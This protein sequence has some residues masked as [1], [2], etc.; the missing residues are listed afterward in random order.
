MKKIMTKKRFIE[1]L[2]ISW[3]VIVLD[4]AFYFFLNPKNLVFG[5]MMGV[6]T[7]LEPIL[8]KVAN[9]FTASI[10]L[11]IANGI[12]LILGA[13]LLG[14]DFFIKTIYATLLSPAFL[15]LLEQTCNKEFFT[16]RITTAGEY[17]IP[18]LVGGL[19]SGYGIG[20]AVKNN[21]STGG[22]DVIQKC[23]SKYL[24]IPYS[25]TMYLTDWVIVI[26]SGIV[27]KGGFYY[28]IEMV[29]YGSLGI[30]LTSILV[31]KIVLNARSRRTAYIIT[32]KPIEMRDMLYEKISRGVTFS[33]VEGGYTGEEKMMVICTMEKSEAYRLTEF[34]KEVDPDSFSFITSCKEVVGEYADNRRH[35]W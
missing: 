10:F 18:V 5:G 4:I 2:W 13:I 30:L 12:C 20:V 22:M 32:S 27:I 21:G 1:Y 19:L 25:K 26:L 6:A 33:K 15:L 28:D 23:M 17:A 35:L 11:F 34:I 3:G 8:L 31:D 24:H 14:K 7:L 16:G 29:V 9:W